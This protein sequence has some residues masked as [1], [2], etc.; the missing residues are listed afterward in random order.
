MITRIADPKNSQMFLTS[1]SLDDAQLQKK[2][3]WY[4]IEYSSEKYSTEFMDSLK[5]PEINV[6][7]KKLDLPP[8]NTLLPK[9][10]DI[11]ADDESLSGAPVLLK[12][13]DNSEV[14]YRKD[15]KFKRPK[16]IVSLKVYTNDN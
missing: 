6:Q 8:P 9:N 7:G 1:Q 13:F 15:D 10:F 16:G 5:K 3:K 14:W 11:L 2:E 12:A 4:K